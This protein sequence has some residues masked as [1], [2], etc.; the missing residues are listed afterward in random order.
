M[1]EKYNAQARLFKALS[2]E[3]R[4]KTLDLLKDKSYNASELLAEVDFSQ[5]TLSHH[6]KIMLNS[7]IVQGVKNGKWTIYSLKKEFFE[8]LIG[9]L[10]E[11][12]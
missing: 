8:E 7:G 11:Y 10:E 2:D 4:L 12:L 5:S 9:W 3:N 6:M 1:N